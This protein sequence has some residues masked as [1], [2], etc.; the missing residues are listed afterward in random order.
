[1]QLDASSISKVV[2]VQSGIFVDFKA[3]WRIV[4]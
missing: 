2:D 1:M 4:E 3:R